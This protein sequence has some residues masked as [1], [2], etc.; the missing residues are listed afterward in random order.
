MKEEQKIVLFRETLS[1][2]IFSDFISLVVLS[3]CVYISKDSTWWTFV[4]GFMFIVFM[5]GK[6]GVVT[7]NFK[8][9][10]IGK[11]AL[12]DYANRIVTGK[13]RRTKPLMI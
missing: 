5:I 7:G 8:T 9:E 6:I 11:Q 4:T 12:I 13:R 10:I 2:S 1:Q 3:F